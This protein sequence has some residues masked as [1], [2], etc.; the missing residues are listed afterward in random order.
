VDGSV[1]RRYQCRDC[2]ER[3][4]VITPGERPAREPLDPARRSIP[5]KLTHEKI[6]RILTE[7]QTSVR[8]FA[9]ELG[10]SC[11]TIQAIRSGA[12]WKHAFPEILRNAKRRSCN[13]C[14]HWDRGECAIGF[15]DPMEEGLGF[16]E[17][18]EFYEV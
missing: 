7:T 12:T 13:R 14:R 9:A 8:A 5:R 10:V 16:A 1:R 11:Q 3:W 2:G 4:T 15:P 17:D 6:Y 18:C